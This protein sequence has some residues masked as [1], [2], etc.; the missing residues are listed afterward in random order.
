MDF[1]RNGKSRADAAGSHEKMSAA[2]AEPMSVLITGCS[3]GIGRALALEYHARGCRVVATARSLAAL[4]D[5]SELGITVAQVDVTRPEMLA[6]AVAAHGP[7]EIAVAN[8]GSGLFGPLV[9]E[10]LESFRAL[11]DVNVAGVLATVQAVV[12][13]MAEAG[14][15]VVLVIGSVSGALVTP[16]AGGYCASKAAVEAMCTGLRME[17]APLGVQA[18]LVGRAGR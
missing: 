1:S 18:W 16:F 7:F 15:G 2:A 3:A 8:A 6:A 17:L 10:P 9:E 5:L 4:T 13:A 11:M 12:P 14:H